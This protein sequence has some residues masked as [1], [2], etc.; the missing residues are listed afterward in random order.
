MMRTYVF[1]ETMSSTLVRIWSS[2]VGTKIWSLRS[3]RKP[4]TCCQCKQS[5]TL[6]V[7][8][9]GPM[10]STSQNRADRLCVMCVEL[11]VTDAPTRRSR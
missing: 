7:K 3:L 8:G 11:M 2:D 1:R 4:T 9:W 10:I 6:P 5:L